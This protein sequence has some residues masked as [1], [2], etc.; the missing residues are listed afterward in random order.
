[1]S[2]G[3]GRG[4]ASSVVGGAVAL[5]QADA[6]DLD[7]ALGVHGV[8][9]ALDVHG[10]QLLV[11]EADWRVPAEDVDCRVGSEVRSRRRR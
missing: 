6:V 3:A 1:M 9:V 11:V 10:D 8:V 5:P 7:E 2:T 4:G